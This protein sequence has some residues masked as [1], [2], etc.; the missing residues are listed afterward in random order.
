MTRESGETLWVGDAGAAGFPDLV[1]VRRSRL[2][3]AELKVGK[4]KLTSE[5][6]AWLKD[7]EAVP[8]LESYLW[9]PVDWARIERILR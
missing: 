2:V 7:L 3:F 8:Y 1:L 9:W 6:E 4:N 5:Q